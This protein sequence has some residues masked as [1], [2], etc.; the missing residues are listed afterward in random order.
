MAQ[1]PTVQLPKRLPLALTPENR[2]DK[3]N[4]DAKLVNGYLEKVSEGDYQL[5]GRPGLGGA[6]RPSGGNAPGYG[7]Y[8][9]LGDVYSVFGDTM[10][11]NTTAIGTV[12]DTNGVYQWTQVSGGAPRLGLGNGVAAY[13]TD[14]A[15]VTQIPDVDFP[16]TFYKGWAYLDKT[17]YVMTSPNKIYGSGLD[18]LSDWDL[19]NLIEA[20]IAPDTG[21]GMNK[22]LVYAIAFK[23]WTTEVFYD[24]VNATGSPLSPVQGAKLNFGC[25]SIDTVQEVDGVLYWVCT[26]RNSSPQIL[27]MDNLKAQII[28]TSAIERLISNADFSQCYSW[29][30]KEWGHWF[31]GVTFKNNNL[32]LVYDIKEKMWAQWSDTDGNYYPI[33]SATF[34]DENLHVFQHESN[35]RLYIA[36]ATYVN[37]DG[38]LFTV[39]MVTPNFDGGTR[40]GKQLN[41]MFFNGDKTPGS[42]LQVRHNDHDFDPTKW[43]NFRT[44]DMNAKRPFLDKCGTFERRAYNL[45][46]RCNTRLR[47]S[48]VDLQMDLCVL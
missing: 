40:R 1:A 32:T 42:I 39:D 47:I 34:N 10:Y 9:W 2:A 3:T 24:A 31:Y 15:T 45:R 29:A 14:G 48:S 4:K 23:Q 30:V 28:S 33:V 18:D 17:T 25:A 21:V 12:D 27:A 46:H 35:G 36:D 8:N 6:V 11:K 43:T 20:Q 5:Y 38:A 44:V 22:Q 19:L 16:A 37:D 13:T 26:N 7:C 41:M